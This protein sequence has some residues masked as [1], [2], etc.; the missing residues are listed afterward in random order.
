MRQSV[1]FAER[2]RRQAMGIHS[3]PIDAGKRTVGPL[4]VEEQRIEPS[5]H[6]L[7]ILAAVLRVACA[8]KR[9]QAERGGGRVAA[10]AGVPQRP[11]QSPAS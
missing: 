10:E 1:R 11:S 6:D 9:Q 4:S 8:E 3:A 2:D 7:A 5:P